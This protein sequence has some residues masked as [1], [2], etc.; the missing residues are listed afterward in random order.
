MT[1]LEVTVVIL[2]LLSLITLLMVGASA[3]KAGSDRATCI[4]NI[5]NVQKAVRGYSNL[6]GL[7]PG[8]T[9]TGL[10]SEI[11]GPGKHMQTAPSCPSAGIYSFGPDLG[12]NTI[13]PIGTLYMKCSLE[14]LR[15]H[16][17]LDNSNW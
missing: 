1:L 14:D 10:L 9:V 4:I 12:V 3:W 6:N 11:I 16:E 17:P 5:S 13:P 2:V 8:M 7:G 15:D